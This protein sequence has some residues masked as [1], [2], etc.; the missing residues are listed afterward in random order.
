[1]L[2]VSTPQCGHS[3]AQHS[4]G[5]LWLCGRCLGHIEVWA[6]LLLLWRS[7]PHVYCKS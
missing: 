2:G 6:Q 3:I 1:V 5:L 4:S 7:C